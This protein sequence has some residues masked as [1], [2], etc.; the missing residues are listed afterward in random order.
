VASAA[1]RRDK[2]VA[3]T[4]EKDAKIDPKGTQDESV[5]M[6]PYW[7]QVANDFASMYPA[8]GYCIAG[9]HKKIKV[10]AEKTLQEVCAMRYGECEGYQRVLAEQEAKQ[11]TTP[12]SLRK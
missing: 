2:G 11:R 7:H 10:M 5:D 8:G 4:T 6:C 1:E 9:C 12:E 3:V